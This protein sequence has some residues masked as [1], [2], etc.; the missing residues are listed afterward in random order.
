MTGGKDAAQ[1][2]NLCARD[3]ILLVI[4]AVVP[5]DFCLRRIGCGDLGLPVKYAVGLIKIHGFG[6]VVRDDGIGLPRLGDTIHLHG[7]Q[8]WYTLTSQVAGKQ[9]CGGRSPTVAEENDARVRLLVRGKIAIMIGIEQ[10][11][12]GVI[13]PL[14]APV[15]EDADVSVFGNS[16]LD[17]TRELNRAVVRVVMADET[18]HETDHDA[19]RSGS[20]PRG[21]IHR[22][23]KRCD[24]ESQDCQSDSR[25]ANWSEAAQTG[26]CG[27]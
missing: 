11:E 1:P 4:E 21:G 12:N 9:H 24:S 17:P 23:R 14:P 26:S 25:S 18:T 22:S 10:S 3:R 2:G 27:I 6:H 15:F 19:G 7:Q 5:E 20:G 8:H 13:G 16:A